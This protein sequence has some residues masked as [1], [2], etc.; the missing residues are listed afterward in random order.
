[1]NAYP[2]IIFSPFPFFINNSA[3]LRQ[4]FTY[5]CDLSEGELPSEIGLVTNLMRRS[6]LQMTRE[7]M[8]F[9]ST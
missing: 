8:H 2:Q 6:V 5:Q 7:G 4:Q 3:T 9:L 1:M